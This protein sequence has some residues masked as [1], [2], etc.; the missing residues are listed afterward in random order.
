[1]KSFLM[2][3]ESAFEKHWHSA[4]FRKLASCL[5]LLLAGALTGTE[6]WAAEAPL[7][8]LI[9]SGQN[10]H[11]WRQTTPK[12]KSVLAATGRFAVDV[13]EHPEKCDTASLAHY[14]VIL[15]DWNTF[16]TPAV[17]NW[18]DSVR[19]ALLAFV[20]GGKGFA[21]VHAGG[22][23]FYDWSEYRQLAVA[24]WAM[25]QTSHGAPH[26]F[27]VVMATDHPIVA[28]LKPF[29]TTDELWVRPGTDPNAQVLASAEGQPIALA[30]RFGQGRSFA[31][32][33]GHSAE[34]MDTPGFQVLFGRG[35]EWAAT[36]KVTLPAEAATDPDGLLKE[37]AAYRFGDSRSVVLRLE[38]LA[39]FLAADTKAKA[40]LARK[41]A[42]LL[43][44]GK[45]SIESR[46]IACSQLSLVGSSDEVPA[47]AKG[48]S[49]A[50]LAYYARLALE[51][52][53]G[54]AADEALREALR[55][56]SGDAC[57]NLIQSLAARRCNAAVQDLAALLS[58][59]D[60]ETAGAAMDGLAAI[61]GAGAASALMAH[62][63]P[64]SAPLQAR[65]AAALLRCADDL[66][67]AG[68]NA[69]AAAVLERLT[70]ARQPSSIR[71]AA[72]PL[73]VKVLGDAGGDVLRNYLSSKDPQMQ[74]V[75][76]RALRANP[77]L[78][79]AQQAANRLEQFPDAIQVQ[80][81]ALLG[82]L[83]DR[84]FIPPLTQAASS[85]N[86][87][88]R[89]VALTALGLAGDASVIPFLASRNVR[90][91]EEKIIGE[92][93]VRLR[94]SDV[95]AALIAT[96]K[97][98]VP[99]SQQELIRALVSRGV[100]Q[101]IPALLEA[102][103]TGDAAVRPRAIGAVGNLG[104]GSACEKLTV[105]LDKAPDAA[106]SAIA[107]IC[108]R[109]NTI[110]PML[111]A[112]TKTN[113]AGKAPLLEAL[114]SIGGTQALEAVRSALHAGDE[115]VSTA[116]LR[117]MANW[118]DSA[119]LNDLI[120]EAS[121]TADSKRKTLAL[122]GI[123][124]LAPLAKD[125]PS[126]K[127]VEMLARAIEMGGPLAEQ[128]K[129]LSAMGEIPGDAALKALKGYLNHPD[130]AA[131]AKAAVEQFNNRNAASPSSPWDEESV[132][133][134]LSPENLCRGAVATN[135]DGLF[136]DG[137]GQGAFAAI[138]G[139]PRTYWDETDRQSL[140]WLRIQLKQPATVACLRLLAFQHRDYAPKL[141]EILCDGKLVKRVENAEYEN[142]LL[143]VDWPP[144][145]CRT[146]ELK[147]TGYYGQSPAIRELGLYSQPGPKH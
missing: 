132:K 105:L 112:L 117:A 147:I 80:L 89:Q 24:S 2:H 7:H 37:L 15:S 109:E 94:G 62:K 143:T 142:N 128:K 139:D 63:N 39:A 22:S 108:R 137:Q 133:I 72:F 145:E 87:A 135:L 124:R 60:P 48:L 110:Q 61:G 34:F 56:S 16:G 119:P 8:A 104:D 75:A 138:D 113:P 4:R 32:L 96:L 44:D 130:L 116:A 21:V 100:K 11:D 20:R 78:A 84:S 125:I 57:R 55:T 10:N 131:E 114:A 118:P 54:S 51:R 59:E 66:A 1:M 102:A 111:D 123:A 92:A 74:A 79:L 41:L 86:Q 101:A 106:A 26:S 82:E 120:S 115:I 17:T 5:S 90:G 68:Q 12:L 52:I 140:Y 122:R 45:A 121:A 97:T 42:A 47:L 18:P 141:F 69:Q 127:A 71:L 85:Q 50:R 58:R 28:G 83:G 3:W 49:D 99:A 40:N 38:R 14:D 136:P 88:V 25:G 46:Q 31:L 93:F 77:S 64:V 81:I 73:Y 91:D 126:A 67:A 98:A 43:A 27:T 103:Q 65:L 30:G 9:L 144:A 6:A 129:L 23:S 95:D 29:T 53:P 134:F 107:E 13:T 70:A 35:M 19:E 33:L 146:L 76:I 36:G